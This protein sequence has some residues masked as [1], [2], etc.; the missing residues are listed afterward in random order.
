MALS[1]KEAGKVPHDAHEL[2]TKTVNKIGLKADEVLIK[3]IELNTKGGDQAAQDAADSYYYAF[4]LVAIILG[5]AVI[6]GI[7]VGFYLVQDV[8]AASTRSS[9]RCRRWARATSPPKSRIAA[10]RPRSAP[11]PTCCRSSRRR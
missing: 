1:R 5:A 6:I 9:S 8:S 11:W 4:M 10:R 7:G 2:N 3:D